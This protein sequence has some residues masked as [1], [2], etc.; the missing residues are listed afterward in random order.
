VPA[1]SSCIYKNEH[2]ILNSNGI[3]Q[4]E[5]IGYLDISRPVL[6]SF[7][8]A[9]VKLVGL[10]GYQRAY[11]MYMLG[12]Y[13]APHR[14]SVGVSFDYDSAVVQ[15]TMLRPLNSN[16]AWGSDQ[17]WGSSTP[18][19]GGGNT[20]R[21]RLFFQRQKCQAVQITLQETFDAAD[22]VAGAGLAL[23]SLNFVIG[24]KKGYPTVAANQSGG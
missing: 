18:W 13:L 4:Q 11:F 21:Y 7:T 22:G 12:D 20:E 17:L 24:A 10:Q 5:S 9:W 15:E 3:V 6:V 14:L 8:T 23:S 19:G 16:D 1:I 2:T